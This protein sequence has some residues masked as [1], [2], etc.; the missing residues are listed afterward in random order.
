[1][2]LVVALSDLNPE[3][4]NRPGKIGP[5]SPGAVVTTFFKATADRPNT[6]SAYLNHYPGGK[7]RYSAAHFHEADQ[8]QIIVQGKGQFG[9]HEVSPYCVHFSRAYTPYGPLLSDEEVGW[10]FLVLRT[11]YDPGAQRFPE[12]QDAL[13]QI[14]NRRPWQITRKVDFPGS[15]QAVSLTDIPWIKDDLGLFAHTLTL[16][17]N[18]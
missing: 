8:F 15:R 7:A 6:P 11:R 1:M 5:G 12:S 13:K 17:P 18:A 14:P 16:A 9:R 10:T 3:Q 4:V 2:T